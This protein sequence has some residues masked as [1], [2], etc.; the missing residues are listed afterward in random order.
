MGFSDKTRIVDIAV[1]NLGINIQYPFK[2]CL[3]AVY[4]QNLTSV[5]V[6]KSICV[7]N[8]LRRIGH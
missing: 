1:L 8:L 4:L 6:V 2:H 7:D 3:D 5:V